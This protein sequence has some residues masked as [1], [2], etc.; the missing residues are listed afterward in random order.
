MTTIYNHQCR[1]CDLHRSTKNVCIPGDGSLKAPVVIVGEAP[2]AGE[3]KTGKPFMGKSGQLL[4]AEL[5]KAGLTD[6]FITNTVH[7]RPPKNRAPTPTELKACRKYLDAELETIQPKAIL[8]LGA[9][10]MKAITKRAGITENHGRITEKDGVIHMATFHPAYALRDPTKLP[11]IQQDLDRFAR[12]LKG[13]RRSATVHWDIVRRENLKKFVADLQ[14]CAEFAFDLETSG[15]KWYNPENKYIR[16]VGLGLG[17]EGG[18]DF[19]WVIP[20]TMPGSPF[21]NERLQHEVM[22]IV[23]ETLEGKPTCAHNG[24]FDNLWLKNVIGRKFYLN[25]D[26]MLAKHTIDENTPNDLKSLVRSILDEP[27]YE[28]DL[29]TKKGGGSAKSLYEY[30]ARDCVYTLRLKRHFMSILAKDHSLRRLFL[31]LIMPAARAFEDIDGNGLHVNLERM[32]ETE[33]TNAEMLED[34]LNELNE[35]AREFTKREINWNSP[36]QVAELL[37]K[38]IGIDCTVFTDKGAPSTGE[39]ALIA[40]KS[41]HPIADKLVRYRELEKFRST[42]LEGWK[43]FMVDSRLYLSTKL[44]GTV[45]GRYSN[46][47]HQVPRDGTIRN[48]IEAPPG[49]QFVQADLSQAEM[50]VAAIMSQDTE[51]LTCYR[52]GVDVHW[53]TLMAMINTGD[54]D[55]VQLAIKT[56]EMYCVR[57]GLPPNRAS[58]EVLQ[59]VWDKAPHRD[60]TEKLL[61]KVWALSEECRTRKSDTSMQALQKAIQASGDISHLLPEVSYAESRGNSDSSSKETSEDDRRQIRRRVR[62]QSVGTEESILERGNRPSSTAAVEEEFMRALWEYTQFRRA[63]QGSRSKQQQKIQLSDALSILSSFTPQQAES[64]AKWKEWR[65]RAKSINFGFLFSM[66]EKKFIETAT[67]KYGFTPTFEEAEHF[68][69]LYFHLYPG[70]LKWHEK[71]RRLVKLNGFVRN[72]AG[73]VRRLPGIYSD[74]WSIKSECERQAINSPVQGY[75]GDHKAMA[76]VEIH[77]TFDSNTELRIVGEVH[78]AILMWVRTG[79]EDEVLPRVASIMR[80]PRLLKE[81]KINLPVP[82]EADITVGAWGNGAAYRIQSQ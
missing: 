46:R 12:Y 45:T 40:I 77:E 35:M 55:G 17:F 28:V 15:L 10:A 42:Y 50:R 11:F 76:V 63:S 7:C 31:R 74:E 54:G 16:C 56:I 9:V 33:I 4:R 49:W 57:H 19:G 65:K 47:L 30:N 8:T 22:E 75:I 20:M 78:D 82:L 69:R 39:E 25:F 73:R 60:E 6:V 23:F 58:C 38:D 71:Q 70:L 80:T 21:H 68:R 44:H 64:L 67:L 36:Q 24:K 29:A 2:G 14:R 59:A 18:S 43:E 26:T 62:E 81:F 3:E 53:R 66:H 1:D 61:Q 79:K 48:L 27:D 13:E 32:R 72:F 37:Y 34:E 52:R 41:Q 5:L 51:L